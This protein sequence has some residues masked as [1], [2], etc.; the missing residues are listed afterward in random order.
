MKKFIAT[1]S[2]KGLVVSG[3]T[4]KGV[5]AST[6]A[7]AQKRAEKYAAEHFSSFDERIVI[8]EELTPA[9][10]K[11]LVEAYAVINEQYLQIAKLRS[12]LEDCAAISKGYRKL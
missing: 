12:M 3:S 10:E 7:V 1:I 5:E 8:V 11:S 2:Y 9:K 4:V 6:K